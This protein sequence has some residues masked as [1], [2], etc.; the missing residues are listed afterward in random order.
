MFK[1]ALSLQWKEFNRGKSIGEKL[2]AKILKWFW[3]VYFAF[4]SVMMGIIASSY[5]GPSMK[6]PIKSDSLAS[7]EYVN[8]Q[9]IYFFAYLIVM[10]YFI[11]SLPVLNIRA[12]LLT[13]ISKKQIVNY[14]LLRTVLTYFNILPLFFL[15]PFSYLLFL[16]G[17]YKLGSL[18][19]WNINIVGI[20][21]LTNFLNFLL[22]NKNT[23]IYTIG[24][25]LGA[26]KALEYFSIIDITIYSKELFYLFY[27]IPYLSVFTWVFVFWLYNYVKK[28]FL[29]GLYIDTGLQLKIKKA[30][31]EDFSWLDSFGKTAIF[32]KND[33][34]LLKRSK[35]GRTAVY[36]SIG[37]LFYGL[38][39]AFSEDL[40]GST[41]SFFGYLFSSGGFLFMFGSFV[42][43]WDS[44]Y[45]PLMM[46]Q[47]IEYRRYLNSKWSLM[48]L[49]T[50]ISTV[51]AL[52][53][54]SFFGINA[55]F[56]VIAG[57]AY[58]MGVNGYLTLWAGAYTKSPIDLNSSANA[59][60]DKKAFNA[61]TILVGLPQI[62]LPLMVYYLGNLYYGHV[63]ACFFVAGLGSL[64]IFLKPFAFKLIMKAYKSEKYS[65]L[66]AY[67]SN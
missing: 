32:I 28:Y 10:R 52:V 21:Y 29:G 59:F 44:Q 1:T 3:I 6:F 22:N 20:I 17:E 40:Y 65:T 26:I 39:F 62:A 30:K 12:F 45:Y 67:K 4:M 66:K 11:Q 15:I 64:G 37:C 58:N 47:N 16:T 49:G 23:L 9:L 14:S 55:V 36:M 33:L 13:T 19:F 18:I 56:A 8:G 50:I 31:I 60:G 5:G 27:D 24:G 51:F 63:T 57:S 38:I 34:R 42:P 2:V 61:K 7:F 43:S 25:F 46:T 53:I 41:G 35:R 54:Y 48:I